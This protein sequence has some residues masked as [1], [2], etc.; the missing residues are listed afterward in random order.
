[1]SF[2]AILDPGDEVLIYE[3]YWVS[4]TEEVKLCNGVPITIP[5]HESI[6]NTEKYITKN[7]KC[8]IINNPQNPTGKI[9][10]ENELEQIL[11]LAKKY[12]LYI[13]SD[14]AYSDFIPINTSFHSMGKID[15]AKEYSIVCNSM[16]K[17]YGISG[18]RL[19]YVITNAALT[20]EIL[21][22]N[23]HL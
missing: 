3:P 6:S 22:I 14:E 1:M 19:G 20:Y 11:N 16:S 12:D 13:L 17:N 4:Y 9:Y 7:T 21:K 2:M 15:D 23:Q 18:W 5:Y 10:T 8:I